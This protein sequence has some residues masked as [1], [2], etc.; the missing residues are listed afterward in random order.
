MLELAKIF[1]INMKKDHERRE[2]LE[3]SLREHFRGV[4]FER[5]EA[6]T[7]ETMWEHE[8]FF[9]GRLCDRL[10]PIDGVYPLPGTICCNL[11][12]YQALR[13]IESEWRVHQR[14][15]CCYL[16]LEDDCVFDGTVY[17]KIKNTIFPSLP[18][19]WKLVKHSL[20]KAIQNDRVGDLFFDV[21]GAR[22]KNWDYYW[23]THF[24]IYNGR[25]IAEIIRLMETTLITD[26]DGWMR[27]NIDGNYS[28]AQH[29]HIKQSNL[30]GSNTNPNYAS[31]RFEDRTNRFR[32]GS[33]LSR[34]WDLL[35]AA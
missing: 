35:R 29:M 16:L 19:D 2:L 7:P 11:S 30:G 32:R 5:I 27:C 31:P 1:F 28:F 9:K 4:P 25:S 22:D 13:K 33:I 21:S 12:H 17:P 26:T 20:G 18:E 23:G 8:A 10:K 3:A 34:A 6:V 15:D 14:P 24:V